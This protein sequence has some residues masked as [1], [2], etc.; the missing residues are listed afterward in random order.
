MILIS[1]YLVP[2]GYT[3]FTIF[4]FV[5]LK[6]KDLK[7]HAILVN[8]EKI[9]LR[10]QLEMLII[11]FYLIYVIEFSIRLF[12]YKKWDLAYR[13]ISFERE[14]YANEFN[15]YYLKHRSFWRFLKYLRAN[16]I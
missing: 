16:D 14:A 13:N 3:G 2:K 6:S 10:Q 7:S 15:L 11:P 8:H 1:K 12:Q 4:P 5:F 9:H